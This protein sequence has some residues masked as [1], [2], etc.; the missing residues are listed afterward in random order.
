MLALQNAPAANLNL[1]RNSNRA[2]RNRDKTAKFDLTFSVREFEGK[3]LGNVDYRTDLFE[4]VTIERMLGHFQML[5]QGIAAD[6]EQRISQ[7]PLLMNDEKRRLLVEWNDTTRDCPKTESIHELFEAQAQ[8]TPDA[9]AM[10]FE[11]Q[12]LTYRELNVRA[13]QLAHYLRQGVGPEVPVAICMERYIDMIVGLLGILKAGGAYVPLDSDYPKERLAF[14]LEDTQ[15]SVLLT[16]QQVLD[17]LPEHKGQIVCMDK[18]REQIAQE[19]DLNPITA[20]KCQDLAYVIYTSGTAGTPKG[21]MI[22]HRSLVNYLCWFNGSPLAQTA[23]SLPVITR[24]TFDASLKQLFAPLLRAGQVW[25]PSDDVVNHPLALLEVLSARTLVG[26]NCVPSLWKAVLED[27]TPDR[28]IALRNSLSVLLLGG[29]QIDRDLVDR[30]FS[31]MPEIKIWNLY[32]PT[33]A[34]ANACVGIVTPHGA[35]TVGRPIA[36]SRVYILDPHLNPVPIGV[37]GELHVGG[38]G[39]ARGYLNRSE[40]TTEKFIANP[41]AAE[42]TSRLYKTGDLARYLPDGNIEFLGRIDD[43]VKIRG[44]RIEPGEI[45]TVMCQLATVQSSVIVVRE[46]DPGDKR[47]VAYVVT[48]PEEAFNFPE[49]RKFLKQKLPEYMIP[50]AFVLLDEL[51]LTSSGK[52]DRRALPVPDHDRRELAR[53]YRGPRTATETTLVAIWREVLKLGQVGI[54]DNFF[55]L[56]GHSLLV[57]Q[58]VSR[59]RKAFSVEIPLRALFEFPTIAEMAAVIV[60]YQGKQLGEEELEQ[61]MHTLELMT[62]EDTQQLVAEETFKR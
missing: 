24:A 58:I 61:M 62:E 41:F 13:N 16:Q 45:E 2:D 35:L 44:Y 51:P 27:L 42:T 50:S 30:T 52:I 22:E 11:D 49:V 37:S 25:I 7:L 12:Q 33:E 47:L 26:L 17:R 36:N 31:A 55:D 32:G 59:I 48:R 21:V 56:G 6:P 19:S 23:Q 8:R 29:E 53:V 46:D 40:L 18:D 34:T 38:D 14:M 9:M 15:V 39:L 10:V 5:V 4:S 60:E 3:L 28:A 54:D 20:V 43:Q 57:V 1:A